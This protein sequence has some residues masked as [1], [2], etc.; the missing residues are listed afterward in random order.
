MS[1]AKSP[2]G[3]EDAI[4][5]IVFR[6][7]DSYVAQCIEYDIAVQSADLASL[8]DRLQL[9]LEAEFVT[10][11]ERGKVPR[12]CIIPAPNYYHELWAKRTVELKRINVPVAQGPVVQIAMAA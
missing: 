4:R 3:S 10:C 9:T 8:V 5:A 1:N 7:G 11:E 2:N 12:D 6:A